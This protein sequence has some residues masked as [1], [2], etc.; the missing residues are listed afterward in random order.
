M[1]PEEQ[2]AWNEYWEKNG[3]DLDGSE[4]SLKHAFHSGWVANNQR[5]V[6][7]QAVLSGWSDAR[8]REMAGLPP[9]QKGGDVDSSNKIS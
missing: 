2:K 8:A 5:N 1:S 3:V 4:T 9:E 7:S 6:Y